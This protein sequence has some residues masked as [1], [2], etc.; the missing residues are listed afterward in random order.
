MNPFKTW[1]PGTHC[2]HG[3]TVA[4]GHR[5]RPPEPAAP[6]PLRPGASTRGSGPWT[7]LRLC[8]LEEEED[9]HA[10]T[11]LQ[12]CSHLANGANQ[13]PQLPRLT[14]GG[15]LCYLLR[16]AVQ[17]LVHLHTRGVPVVSKADDDHAVLLR[18]D[19]LIHLPAVVQVWEHVRH[20]GAAPGTPAG[21]PAGTV[22]TGSLRPTAGKGCTSHPPAPLGPTADLTPPTPGRGTALRGR[23]ADPV[24]GAEAPGSPPSV[25]LGPAAGR[26]WDPRRPCPR[27]RPRPRPL[28]SST[29]GRRTGPRGRPAD[30]SPCLPRPRSPLRPPA[31]QPTAASRAAA[32]P[33]GDASR[34]VRARGRRRERERE[35]ARGRPT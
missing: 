35:R 4:S 17:H 33:G 1:R 21:T 11:S 13:R 6:Y 30:A 19:G 26:A 23:P 10:V 14:L 32:L 31:P 22:R 28:S 12:P 2:S 3:R 18:Q 15:G 7:L 24:P 34:S 20:L 16:D 9:L 8:S 25:P 29:P 27:P 5:V